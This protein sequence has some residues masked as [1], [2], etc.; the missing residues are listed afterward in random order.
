MNFAG[1]EALLERIATAE[2]E[3]VFLVGAPLTAP[4][5]GSPLGV[6]G[7]AAMV[8]RIKALFQ[9]RPGPLRALEQKLEADPNRY[10]AAFRHV[11][12]FRGPDAANAIIR[13]AVLE[14]R[15]P[16]ARVD[17]AVAHE[18]GWVQ[19]ENDL[20]G[21]HYP[22]AV[23]ALGRLVAAHPRRFGGT[24]LTTN[25]DPLVELSVRRARGRAFSTVLHGDGSLE[26]SRGEGCHVVHVH[27][28]WH[29][30]D[31]LHAPTQLGQDR[32]QLR[33]SLLASTL[34]RTY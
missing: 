23:E 24:V 6:P 3:V 33:A 5:R 16:G 14:A 31:T 19:L 21:W 8:E 28:Y 20:D 25:F 13:D 4:A 10:Q 22:P 11:L 27:G 26:Q 32:P 1:P 34:F 15:V 9:G 18:A 30:M 2:R 12:D 7:V 29:G 17:R